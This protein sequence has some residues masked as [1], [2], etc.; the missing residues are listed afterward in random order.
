MAVARGDRERSIDQLLAT[1]RCR[2]AAGRG[3]DLH[4]QSIEAVYAMP[5]SKID[6][7]G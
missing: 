2:H 3:R 6:E 5:N 1:L 7:A 4:P